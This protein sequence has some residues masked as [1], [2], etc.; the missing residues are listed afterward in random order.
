MRQ[1]TTTRPHGV[2][3]RRVHTTSVP[4]PLPLALLSERGSSPCAGA[5]LR[6]PPS[7]LRLHSGWLAPSREILPGPSPV[8]DPTAPFR[9]TRRGTKTSDRYLLARCM[10]M[11]P[12]K[13]CP[14]LTGTVFPR[15]RQS[16]RPPH[17]VDRVAHGPRRCSSMACARVSSESASVRACRLDGFSLVL[18]RV[19]YVRHS[20]FL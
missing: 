13:R 11:L 17:W 4:L 10:Q 9:S 6:G 18:R 20:H 19:Q 5:P 14:P 3:Y 15:G 1:P 8:Q 12:P 7:G 2:L 16:L